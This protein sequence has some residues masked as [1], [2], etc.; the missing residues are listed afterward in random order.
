MPTIEGAVLLSSTEENIPRWTEEFQKKAPQLDLRVWPN[1]GRVEDIEFAVVARPPSGDLARYPNLRAVFSMWAGVSELL[2]DRRIEHLPIIR[3]TE[4][5][6][7]SGIVT[8]VVH[9]VTGLHLLTSEYKPRLWKH[10]FRVDFRSPS[11]T[12]IGILG[13]GVLGT[14]CAVALR[15]LEFTVTGFSNT[16]KDVPS[17]RSYAG[18]DELR[19]FLEKTDILV[20]LLPT[21]AKTENFLNRETLSYLPKGAKIINCGRGES[22]DDDALLEALESGH[23]SHAVLDVFRVE[24]LPPEHPYWEQPNVLVTPHC[25]SKPDPETGSMVILDKMHRFLNDEPIEGIVDRDLAY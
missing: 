9:H 25:A 21:T 5:G 8:Y 11:H 23:I 18:Q 2:K 10:P 24:P 15:Q 14:A 3:M 17:V 19:P 4:P 1:V 7:T 6:L 20:C 16:R 13:L 22:I 12:R